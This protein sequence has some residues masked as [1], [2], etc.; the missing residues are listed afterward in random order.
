MLGL[1]DG[2]RSGVEAAEAAEAAEVVALQGAGAPR[3]VP[4]VVAAA[5]PLEIANRMTPAAVLTTTV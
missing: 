5:A 2:T 4:A 1:E 3:N